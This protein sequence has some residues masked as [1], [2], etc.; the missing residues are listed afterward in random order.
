MVKEYSPIINPKIENE[1]LLDE[2]LELTP[3]SLVELMCELEDEF[4]FEFEANI[5]DIKMFDDVVNI[6]LEAEVN[7]D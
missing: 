1:S 5:E 4:D 6:V 2:D 3:L 7:R